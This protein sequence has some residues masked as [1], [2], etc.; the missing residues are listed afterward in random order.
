VRAF[1][2]ALLLAGTTTGVSAGEEPRTEEWALAL[3]VVAGGMLAG[4]S[5]FAVAVPRDPVLNDLGRRAERLGVA[6]QA[7]RSIPLL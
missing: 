4:R 3:L 5:A 7:I 6:E 2:A 1:V